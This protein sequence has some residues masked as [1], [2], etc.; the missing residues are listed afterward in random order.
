MVSL[1]TEIGN[2]GATP[3]LEGGNQAFYVAQVGCSRAVSGK[4]KNGREIWASP[5]LEVLK[6]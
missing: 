6:P 1:F 3:D 5:A 4:V 2:R